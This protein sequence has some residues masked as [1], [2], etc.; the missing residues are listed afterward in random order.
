[1]NKNPKTGPDPSYFEDFPA[2]SSLPVKKN[3]VPPHT[4]QILTST[5]SPAQTPDQITNAWKQFDNFN[6]TTSES[7]T[8]TTLSPQDFVYSL[9]TSINL[10][11]DVPYD[12]EN[13]TKE[14]Q[15]DSNG[16]PTQAN[17]RLLQPEFFRKYDLQTLFFI[18]FYFPKTS[19]QYFAGRELKRRQWLFNN[20]YQTWFHRI[21][22]PSER[23]ETYETGKFEYFDNGTN[24]GW[25]IRVRSP[26]TFEYKYLE[27]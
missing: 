2:L 24:E 6:I 12:G 25:C 14:N 8:T 4:T 7:I 11:P 1:M 10:I 23:T 18:F 15:K 9:S 21:G 3:T 13:D 22:E 19:Q 26:F 17:M 27:E 20:K 16:Y 5:P